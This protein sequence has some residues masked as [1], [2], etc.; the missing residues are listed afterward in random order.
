MQ[1]T[2]VKWLRILAALLAVLA[3]S[4]C[5][6]PTD[7]VDKA[8][9]TSDGTS[10]AQA[11]GEES[12]AAQATEESAAGQANII[13][14]PS[15]VSQKGTN[16]QAVVNGE[17]ITNYD[18]QRRAAFLQL[19]RVSGNR[20]EKALEELVDEKIKMQ[21]ARR[22][23][24]VANDSEVD[25]AFANFAKT[26]RMSASQMSQILA[27]SGV[28][29]DHF[30]EFIRNQIS[31]SRATGSKLRSDIVS[32]S[33]QQTMAS[34]RNSGGEKPTTNEYFLEQ[35]IFV[36]PES[37]RAARLKARRAEALA[38]KAN[39]T[40]CGETRRQAIGQTDV[41]VRTLP[42]TLEPELPEEWKDEIIGTAEG[43]TTG[44]K[45]TE[46]GVEFIAVCSRKS[47]SD[48]RAAQ[49]LER[50]QKFE[51][52]NERGSEMSDA[53]FNELKSEAKIIYR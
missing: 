45:D 50:A 35:T 3:V 48:D 18:V 47:V 39:F 16:I 29:S 40:R 30:K 28:T 2:P 13:R 32:R 33:T 34:I 21:E 19:R 11:V 1:Y 7:A 42:R 23:N 37:Q 49:V 22:Q 31:W 24:V 17:P 6:T 5:T 10:L 36:I 38:F 8:D 14:Q 15:T 12:D 41:T 27:R 44:I 52:F 43:S 51:E 46:R 26:N 53:F 25:A 9:D 20:R 4:A